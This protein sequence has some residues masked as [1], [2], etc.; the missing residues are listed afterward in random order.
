MRKQRFYSYLIG[1]LFF[2]VITLSN[3]KA[4]NYVIEFWRGE[5]PSVLPDKLIHDPSDRK[6]NV[7][8]I[9]VDD[10]RPELHC[11]GNKQII[12]PNIDKLAEQGLLF[13][14]AYCQQSLCAPSRASLLTGLRPDATGV[15]D[16]STHFR[17]KVP[18]VVTIPQHFKNHGY[19][20]QSIGKIYH[21]SFE[22]LSRNHNDPKSWS[23]P[24]WWPGPRYYYTPEGVRVAREVYS[25]SRRRGDAPVDNWVN[26]FVR[27]L[28]TEAPDVPDN[29]PCDGQ[30]TEKAIQTLRQIK[31]KP[32]FLG[33]GFLKPHIPFVAPKKYWDLYKREDIRLARNRTR[34]K[35]TPDMAFPEGTEMRSYYDIPDEKNVSDEKARTLIHGYYACVS[36]VDAQVGLVIGELERLG[37]RENTIIILWGDHGWKL[38]EY[39]SWSKLTNFELDTRAPMIISVPGQK[40]A[41]EKTSSLVEFLDIYPTL[42]ELCGLPIPK[43]CQGLSMVPLLDNPNR[44]FKDAAYSQ[45]PRKEYGVMGYSMRTDR[46]RYAEWIKDG[47]VLEKELYDHQNDPQE[48][49]N[50]VNEPGNRQLIIKLSKMLRKGRNVDMGTN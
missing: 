33:V 16:L 39:N 44:K 42:S 32:F 11:Y 4:A 6:M 20:S 37:L 35:N 14:R 30:T 48:N 34:P 46:Y 49:R 10:L 25:K 18:D 21:G 41:G 28:A 27:G 2:Y 12:S 22:I 3:A 40:T 29:V 24:E 1:I 36:Y 8:F 13:E 26:C 45:F 38:G 50:V 5:L 15:C 47:D 23:V 19:H 9:A 31:D 17:K 43:H 7:L